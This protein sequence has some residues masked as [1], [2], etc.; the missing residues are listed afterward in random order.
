MRSLIIFEVEH[1]EDTDD[2]DAFVTYMA[3]RLSDWNLTW[4]ADAVRVDLP[5]CFALDS[6]NR[7]VGEV[8]LP[9]GGCSTATAHSA[10]IEAGSQVCENEEDK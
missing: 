7:G 9:M 10:H 8:E 2:L 4:K 3:D 6:G 5:E 1:G